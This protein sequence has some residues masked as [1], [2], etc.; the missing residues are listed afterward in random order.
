MFDALPAD[1]SRVDAVI[2]EHAARWR[3]E[4]RALA[5]AA[6]RA[7]GLS[8]AWI[9]RSRAQRARRERQRQGAIA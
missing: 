5:D 9:N 8:Q 3:R 2:E 1:W 7:I 4:S 6:Y